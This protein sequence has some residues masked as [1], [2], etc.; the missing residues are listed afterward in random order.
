MTRALLGGE[1][2]GRDFSLTGPRGAKRS[3]I[4]RE[5]EVSGVLSEV[6]ESVSW[7]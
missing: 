2:T 6:L 1:K 4:T 5:R 7:H 3:V